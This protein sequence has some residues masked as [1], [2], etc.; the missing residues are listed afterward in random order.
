M[1]YPFLLFL[2]TL[3]L[4]M[5]LVSIGYAVPIGQNLVLYYSFDEGN[6]DKT[7]DLSGNGNDGTLKGG[8]GWVN[9]KFAKALQFNGKDSYVDCG[10]SDSLKIK[11]EVTLA[12][13]VNLAV[14]PSS[15]GS[16]SRV[17]V[18]ENAGA[19]PFV[20]YGLTVNANGQSGF[21]LEISAAHADTYSK[22]KTIP[23]KGIWYHVAGI[24][25]GS[26]CDIYINGKLENSL[27]ETG[28]LVV[29]P[30]I[31]TMI[32]ADV[33][34]N[35]EYFNGIIDEVVI[36]SRALSSEEIQTL[37][38]KAFSDV[39]SIERKSNLVDLWGNIK[40]QL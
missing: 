4:V 8:V 17:V 25:D 7:K 40:I 14:P 11:K 22:S 27:P 34:R 20:S 6:G 9:G 1:K 35:T 38:N 24:Y 29:N 31:N 37:S 39:L 3:I 32:G 36:Y 10:K 15:L 5:S 13:W 21:G 28:D 26:K 23:E 19:P 2:A 18:R 12:L 16:D 30:N 33:N